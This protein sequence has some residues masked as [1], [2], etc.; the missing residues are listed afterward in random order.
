MSD[1]PPGFDYE[2][3]VSNDDRHLR[4]LALEIYSSDA[5]DWIL[6]EHMIAPTGWEE[7]KQKVKELL[8]QKLS[9]ESFITKIRQLNFISPRLIF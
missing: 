7:Y 2:T 8:E 3:L 4:K 1:Y 6:E 9:E 5:A